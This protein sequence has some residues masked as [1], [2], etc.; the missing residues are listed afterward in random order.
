MNMAKNDLLYNKGM[1]IAIYSHKDPKKKW[2]RGGENIEY[3]KNNWMDTNKPLY[4]LSFTY[5]FLFNNDTVYMA[6]AEPYTYSDILKDIAKFEKRSCKR[7]VFVREPL[8][9][10]VGG[11]V[12]EVLTLTSNKPTK[13]PKKAVILTARAHP[14]ETVSSWMMR[15]VLKYLSSKEAESLLERYIFKIIPCLNPDG[16]IQGNYRSSLAGVDLNRKYVKPSNIL[17]PTI[18]SLKAMVRNLGIPIVLY[19]DLHGHCKMMNFF[20]YGNSIESIST[21]FKLFP[22]I[23]SKVNSYFSYKSSVFSVSRSKASAARIAMWKELHLP[24]VYT[25]EASF[26]GPSSK[27]GEHFTL[28]NLME[29]GRSICK[30]LIVFSLIKNPED[31]N[32]KKLPEAIL[33]KK[34]L[35]ELKENPSIL[36]QKKTSDCSSSSDSNPPENEPDINEISDISAVESEIASSKMLSTTHKESANR[37]AELEEEKV[38]GKR[39]K[40]AERR[41][42][43]QAKAVPRRHNHAYINLIKIPILE[44][45]ITRNYS[46]KPASTQFEF[47]AKNVFFPSKLKIGS[48]NNM[49]NLP[50]IRMRLTRNMLKS[51]FAYSKEY[52]S[53]ESQRQVNKTYSEDRSLF[54]KINQLLVATKFNS[55]ECE[56]PFKVL[57]FITL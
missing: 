34:I 46:S 23:L 9:L 45:R 13:D 7:M 15:G 26:Y 57:L 33:A 14:G 19:C 17:H 47:S 11:C 4:I 10:T 41:V 1:K 50:L 56:S 12:C 48:R 20:A 5:E 3:I 49:R 54:P 36:N 51:K 37:K 52:I 29:M 28:K 43:N 55:N 35:N 31:W 27:V 30:G 25:I 40:L 24:S 8:C 32:D 42:V 39:V 38:R 22:Y 53:N 2:V 16:V 6:F 18:Y 21:E 44:R